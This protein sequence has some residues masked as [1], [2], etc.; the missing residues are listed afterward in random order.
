MTQLQP[1]F[2]PGALSGIKV[3][4]ASRVLGGPL[5]GQILADHGADVL[6]VESPDGDDT[7]K[8]GPPFKD[9]MSAYFSGLNRNKSVV[10]VD[11]SGDEGRDQ[12]MALLEDADVLIENFKPSTLAEWGIS[13]E[14]LQERFP[15]LVHCRVSGFGPDGPLGGLPAYDTAVQGMTGL[16]SVNGDA[17]TGP[18][19]VGLPVVDMTTALNATI[20]VLLALQERQRSGRGQL[21]ETTLYDNGLSLL[22]PHAANYFMTSR[23]PVATGNAHP[24]I[25]PYDAFETRTRAVYLAVGNDVQYRKLCAVLDEPSLA[26]DARFATA[27]SRSENRSSL[28]PLLAGLFADKEGCSFAE[29]LLAAGV[30]ASAIVGVDSALSHPHTEHRGMVVSIGESYRGLGSPIALSR[31]PATYRTAPP[32]LPTTKQPDEL[33]ANH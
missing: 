27:A 28:K 32:A 9:G 8:W 1:H 14:K 30:P 3:I 15:R 25:Y 19:R 29:Q 22:H 12:L 7:R 6:K 20:G 26:A 21:V 17:S 4:D 5:C 31:T 24:N 18:L 16:M 33:S 2:S 11:L 10:V 13:P 23:V